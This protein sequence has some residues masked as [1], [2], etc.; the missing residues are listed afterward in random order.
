MGSTLIL[1]RRKKGAA[2]VKRNIRKIDINIIACHRFL[3]KLF[4]DFREAAGS[5]ELG[6]DE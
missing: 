1:P 5:R 3:S 4:N 2:V 6:L